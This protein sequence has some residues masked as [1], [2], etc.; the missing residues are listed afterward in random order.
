VD[1]PQLV[2]TSSPDDEILSGNCSSCRAVQFRFRGNNLRNQEIMRGM[3]E[4]HFKRVHMRED[5]SQ[6]PSRMVKEPEEK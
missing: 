5:A 6:N 3:F 1:K 4:K 2:I